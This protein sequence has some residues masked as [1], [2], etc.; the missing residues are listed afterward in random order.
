[1]PE[2]EILYEI[3]N[4]SDHYTLKAA[5]YPAAWAAILLLGN[6]L[7]GLKQ[8]DPPP[9]G[10]ADVFRLSPFADE[11]ELE[12]VSKEICG[13]SLSEFI[14]IPD[15][16]DHMAAALES[17][18]IGD[19]KLYEATIAALAPGKRAAWAKQWKDRNRSSTS[20]IGASA[21][22]AAG[23][24]RANAARRRGHGIEIGASNE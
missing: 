2:P 14:A 1:M 13:C 15:N 21:A 16:M 22:W 12:A 9:Q 7:Y 8:I 5:N 10:A 11:A 24:L 4:P 17:V 23:R 6:G 20:D 3:V 19:R 18:V